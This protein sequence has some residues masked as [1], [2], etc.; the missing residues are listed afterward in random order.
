MK[1]RSFFRT[2]AISAAILLVGGTVLWAVSRIVLQTGGQIRVYPNQ[3]T[4]VFLTP[5]TDEEIVL[6]PWTVMKPYGEV[7]PF[8]T[9]AEETDITEKLADA[10]GNCVSFF[11]K[12]GCVE[13]V[14]AGKLMTDTDEKLLGMRDAIV[15]C[16]LWD[17]TEADAIYDK[18]LP[19][20]K[21]TFSVSFAVQMEDPSLCYLEIVPLSAK[22][23]GDET[24]GYEALC[25]EAK[26]AGKAASDNNRFVAFF[27][28]YINLC[29]EFGLYES[30]AAYLVYDAVCSGEYTTF[31]YDGRAYFCYSFRGI[32]LTVFCDP[33][34]GR[35]LGFSAETTG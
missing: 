5:K 35:V 33:G 1:H 34:T 16:T 11:I 26:N 28:N 27:N 25:L 20:H 32:N 15:D 30:K 3:E 19:S 13:T 10:A 6:Y 29:A 4:N 31:L 18:E 9:Q 8:Y 2:L 22:Q 24:V 17:F 7:E 23:E 21:E 14:K 12:N